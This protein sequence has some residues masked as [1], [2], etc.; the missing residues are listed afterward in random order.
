MALSEK[1]KEKVKEFKKDADNFN[2]E[3][4]KDAK[5]YGR[6]FPLIAIII[7]AVILVYFVMN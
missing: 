7:L 5:S 2:N 1:E 4:Y 3:L 6:F